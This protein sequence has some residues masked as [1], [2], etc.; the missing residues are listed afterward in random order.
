MESV[1]FK[2]SSWHDSHVQQRLRTTV[3]M[4]EREQLINKYKGN[5]LNE[6]S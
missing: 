1:F 2:K 3:L 5:V 4:A 6:V